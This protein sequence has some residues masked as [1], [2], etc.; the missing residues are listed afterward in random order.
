MAPSPP[1]IWAPSA[2]PC[3]RA[4]SAPP[5]EAE[6]EGRAA[7]PAARREWSGRR[8]SRAAAPPKE[9]EREGPGHTSHAATPPE[10]AEREGR[11][12]TLCAAPS[13]EAERERRRRADEGR[14]ESVSRSTRRDVGSRG[15][16]GGCLRGGGQRE[17]L[18]TRQANPS[19]R[20]IYDPC[21]WAA[22]GLF[23]LR[24]LL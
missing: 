19:I 2:P 17:D 8:Q 1:W 12:A 14:D 22:G 6:K 4:P 7:V 18:D 3:H 20:Y 10:E 16:S 9:S 11:A 15:R 13:K 24:N 23:G 21:Y 5:E